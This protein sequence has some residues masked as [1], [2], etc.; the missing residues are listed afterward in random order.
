M[1]PRDVLRDVYFSAAI[2]PM[3]GKRIAER[4]SSVDTQLALL[5]AVFVAARQALEKILYPRQVSQAE[6]RIPLAQTSLRAEACDFQ[7]VST[8]GSF[9]GCLNFATHFTQTAK[10]LNPAAPWQVELYAP[11]L[12]AYAPASEAYRHRQEKPIAKVALQFQ[13]DTKSSKGLERHGV[14]WPPNEIWYAICVVE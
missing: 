12:Q 14:A 11:D 7:P 13:R 1:S 8:L 4:R 9:T 3:L 5:I 2:W 10:D 6:R